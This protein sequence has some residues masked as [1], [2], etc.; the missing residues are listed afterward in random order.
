MYDGPEQIERNNKLFKE[1][2]ISKDKYILRDR[3]H[4]EQEEFGLILTNRAGTLKDKKNLPTTI[5]HYM[6]Y[7][8]QID[9]NGD[10][11]FCVQ[12]VYDKSVTHGN[13]NDQSMLDVWL[14]KKINDYRKKLE[15]GDRDHH[16]CK[17]CDAIG[18]IHG[19]NH[20]MAWKFKK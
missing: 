16:P 3:W 8:M 19:N 12:S 10:V 11:L 7:S 14:S 15:A 5:C 20:V 6:H 4:S 18:T 2:E 13:L 1:A 17:N 9:W